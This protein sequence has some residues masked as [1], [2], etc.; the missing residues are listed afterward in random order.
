MFRVH[1]GP[2][3]TLPR[4]SVVLPSLNQANY[5]P[6]ALDSILGQSY[7][8][9]ELILLDGGSEDGSGEVISRYAQRLTYWRST[10]DHGQA[11][12]INEG[13]RRAT[14]SVLCWLNSDDYY[15]PGSFHEVGRRL[16]DRTHAPLVLYGGTLTTRVGASSLTVGAQGASP[17]DLTAL[18][19]HNQIPQPSAFWTRVAW[20]RA[21]AL[22]EQLQY[23][24]DWDWFVRA[25]RVAEFE[26]LPQFLSVYRHHPA[27][28]SGRGGSERRAEIRRVVARYASSYWRRLYDQVDRH[29]EVIKRRSQILER[30][31]LP[32]RHVLLPLA[33]PSL[34]LRLR[35][36]NDLALIM[37]V[38]G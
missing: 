28:K 6:V 15:L 14:G 30:T 7:P 20:E 27:H 11:A 21:G 29:Y 35:R 37:A 13:F 3:V 26:W 31:P 9:F 8:D 1:E 2:R 19:H 18:P 24:M 32:R 12:A 34:W 10:P 22:D 5:L 17:S 33:M 16:A 4:L 23:T 25:S 38:Y 36:P